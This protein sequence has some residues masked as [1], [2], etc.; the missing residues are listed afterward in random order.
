M[1]LCSIFSIITLICLGNTKKLSVTSVSTLESSY[2]YLYGSSL[3]GTVLYIK[4]TGFQQNPSLNRVF[5]GDYPC[6]VPDEGIKE[7][8]LICRT[9]SFYPKDYAY[10]LPIVIISKK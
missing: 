4:G 7:E 3:G 8:T 6:I 10:D 9:S 1:L 2:D 5:V